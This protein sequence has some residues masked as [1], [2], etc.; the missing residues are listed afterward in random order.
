VEIAHLADLHMNAQFLDPLFG[1]G[2]PSALM[3]RYRA[4]FDRGFV[5]EGDLGR[6]AGPLSF[7][8]VNYYRPHAITTDSDRS[9]RTT[10]IPGSLGGWDMVPRGTP[11]TSMGWPIEPSGLLELLL[12]LDR[13]YSPGRI[14]LTENGAAF[15]DV[16]G[17]DGV[18]HDEPRIAFLHD[19]VAAAGRAIAAGVPLIGYLV[20]SLLDNFE[21]AEG[22]GKRFGLVHVD[23][24]TQARTP[25]ASARWFQGLVESGS[26]QPV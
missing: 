7:L 25:K 23:Y 9:D 20:W 22:Y 10:E 14:F 16:P 1:R 12:R 18:V 8:G 24:E 3:E 13:E 26:S 4:L 6:I 5:R 2:Y 19:H 21:W 15:D 17:P 11:I